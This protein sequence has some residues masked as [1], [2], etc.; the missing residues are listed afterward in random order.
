[1][2]RTYN[3]GDV[4]RGLGKLEGVRKSDPAQGL[5]LSKTKE[6]WGYY[7]VNGKRQ[8]HVSAK[9]H[10]SGD[11]AIGRASNIRKLL[12]LNG[13]E[14]AD[15]CDCRLTGPQYHQLIIERLSIEG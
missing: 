12:K 11:V 3:A 13:Q 15:L 9:R 2:A 4:N 14:F 5:Q 7:W 10:S 8:F 6:M 1:M